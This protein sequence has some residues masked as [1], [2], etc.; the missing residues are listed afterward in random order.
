MGRDSD[1][2]LLMRLSDASMDVD[3]GEIY[4]VSR[5]DSEEYD[6]EQ[7]HDRAFSPNKGLYREECTM[8]CTNCGKKLDP[9]AAACVYCGHA[10]AN[11]TGVVQDGPSGGF[12]ALG[13]FIPLAG[14][15]LYLVYEGKQ[16]LRAKSA[17]KGALIGF[18]IRCALSAIASI[19]YAIYSFML[20][21]TFMRYIPF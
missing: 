12:A 16:P 14:L 10:T 3:T 5:W 13:F 20:I 15:I 9:N 19:L 1:G 18:L 11:L 7:N 2:H 21:D 6:N 17:G 8:Y 4:G